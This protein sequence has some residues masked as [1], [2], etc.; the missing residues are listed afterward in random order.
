MRRKYHRPKQRISDVIV[1]QMRLLFGLAQQHLQRSGYYVKMVKRL[2]TRF[3]IKVPA[4]IKKRYCKHCG[5]MWTFE[6]NV[7]VRTQKGKLVYYC[8]ECKHF[9]RMPFYKE[10]KERRKKTNL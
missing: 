9:T 7:R 4:D 3:K 5:T 1:K 8:L 6:K 10:R 2:N